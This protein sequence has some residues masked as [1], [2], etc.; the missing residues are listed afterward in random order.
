MGLTRP[1]FGM[2]TSSTNDIW[3]NDSSP[4]FGAI[5]PASSVC[6]SSDSPKISASP[7]NSLFGKAV[8]NLQF[9]L[10]ESVAS[11]TDDPYPVKQKVFCLFATVIVTEFLY[12]NPSPL[13]FADRLIKPFPEPDVISLNT[14]K[15]TPARTTCTSPKSLGFQSSLENEHRC[16][17]HSTPIND[18]WSTDQVWNHFAQRRAF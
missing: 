7:R 15:F 18:L 9:Q 10:H 16:D 14:P 4:L 6:S 1:L 8:Q 5:S 13:P 17:E 2:V 12:Q 3:A 11:A